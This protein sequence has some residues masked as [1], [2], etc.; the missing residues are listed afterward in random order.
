LLPEVNL[1][2]LESD[3]LPPEGGMTLDPKNG[4]VDEV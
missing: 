1:G 3:Y 4:R 2:F